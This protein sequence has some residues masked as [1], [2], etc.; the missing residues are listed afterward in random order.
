MSGLP[1]SGVHSPIQASLSWGAGGEA[2]R[3]RSRGYC[4][5]HGL[6]ERG[7]PT[8]SLLA[9]GGDDATVG[10][11]S[12]GSSEQRRSSLGP[13]RRGCP[14]PGSRRGVSTR[15]TSPRWAGAGALPA[16]AGEHQRGGV[17][18]GGLGERE[19]Q[20][21]RLGRPGREVDASLEPAG[22]R[23]EDRHGGAG[24]GAEAEGVVL[25]GADDRGHAVGDG[26]PE[27]VG[28]DGALG[29]GEA[30]SEMHL[31][32]RPQQRGV[33]AHPVEHEAVGVGEH[34]RHGLVDQRLVQPG[35]HL[36][37]ALEEEGLVV[38]GADEGRLD[39]RRAAR[40]SPR[41][42]ATTPRAGPDRC[43]ASPMV[44][45]PGMARCSSRCRRARSGRAGSAMEPPPSGM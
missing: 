7:G 16:R 28:A 23:V 25:V 2:A 36:A 26:E 31:V 10:D 12:R 19:Q 45:W 8:R 35:E 44:G 13:A 20:V 30:G 32:E 33:A 11:G 22:H 18:G 6:G 27:A 15:N 37:A 17:A 9:D 14:T 5:P 39:G 4:S 21:A 38:E 42:A 29:I 40:R 24:V 34:E 43:S 1:S 41:C 3:I